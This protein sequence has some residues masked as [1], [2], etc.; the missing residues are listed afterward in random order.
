VKA[1]SDHEPT[2]GSMPWPHGSNERVCRNE[3]SV[4]DCVFSV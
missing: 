2:Q 1:K 3:T 4:N